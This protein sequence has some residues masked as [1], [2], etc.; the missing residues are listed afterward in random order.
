VH[1]PATYDSAVRTKFAQLV[2]QGRRV[3]AATSFLVGLLVER[4]QRD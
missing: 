1:V 2:T 4:D 3:P